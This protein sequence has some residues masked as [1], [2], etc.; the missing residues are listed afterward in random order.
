MRFHQHATST[1]A[2]H[3]ST[4]TWVHHGPRLVA[5]QRQ[6]YSNEKHRRK[7]ACGSNFFIVTKLNQISPAPCTPGPQLHPNAT[8]RPAPPPP[9]LKN[10]ATDYSVPE[11]C[12]LEHGLQVAGLVELR[13]DVATADELSLDVQLRDGWPFPGD[14][15]GVRARPGGEGWGYILYGLIWLCRWALGVFAAMGASGPSFA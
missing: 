6:R 12:L 2:P 13:Q 8:T 3:V 14:R 11:L 5:R 15:F 7:K 9:R 1:K 10:R 4:Q